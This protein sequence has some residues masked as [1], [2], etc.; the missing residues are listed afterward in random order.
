[1]YKLAIFDMDGTILDT[2]EDLTNSM[3]YALRKHG[4]FSAYN[5]VDMNK[6]FG[7]GV[8]VAVKRALATEAGYNR[9][10]VDRIGNKFEADLDENEVR[11]VISSFEAWYPEHCNIKTKAFA[12]I[13]DC[14]KNLN[15]LGI[16]TAVVSNKMHEAAVI[17]AERYFPGLFK[18]VQGIEEGIKR[19]PNPDATLK[20][21]SKLA[22]SKG[23]TVY[24]GDTEVDIETAKNAG[25]ECISVDWGFRSHKEL[26]DMGAKPIC[27]SVYEMNLEIVK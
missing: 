12:G 23:E 2:I 24:I 4:H 7:S 16:Q 10:A 26:E 15:E 1:M 9:E 21:M 20:I 25:I 6:F 5:S 3:N 17:L 19:K 14:I 8:K 27:S 22:V 13:T 18:C 11:K